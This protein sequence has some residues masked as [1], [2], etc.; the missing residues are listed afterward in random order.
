MFKFLELLLYIVLVQDRAR[1][2]SL[3]LPFHPSDELKDFIRA[4]ESKLKETRHSA[5]VT[6]AIAGISI[7]LP[8][9][10]NNTQPSYAATVAKSA[11]VCTY[12]NKVGHTE[13][14][15]L[16]KRVDLRKRLWKV[17]SAVGDSASA[18][19]TSTSTSEGNSSIKLKQTFPSSGKGH[20]LRATPNS[21]PGQWSSAPRSATFFC[22]AHGTC[23]HSTDMCV[24]LKKIR[25]ENEQG[26][27]AGGAE[28]SGGDST[29]SKSG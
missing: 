27:T 14:K 29:S 4:L 19:D 8:S 13:K 9:K 20:A 18:P 12:C 23:G 21:I 6:A 16:R 3:S 25:E 11:V 24:L 15:C 10:L 22:A 17:S 5:A 7:S 28:I 2:A 1:R 26:R